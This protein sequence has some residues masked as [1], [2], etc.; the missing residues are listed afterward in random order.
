MAC[1]HCGKSFSRGGKLMRRFCSHEC[2]AAATTK[3]RPTYSCEHCKRSFQPDFAHRESRFCSNSC[4]VEARWKTRRDAKPKRYCR[5]CGVEMT[6]RDQKL[7][8]SRECASA[9]RHP[10]PNG[11][12]CEA[13][14]AE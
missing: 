5:Q 4:S 3:Q 7:F 6:K 12:A 13:V 14:P 2:F 10:K 11:F 8:C 9:A 1:H